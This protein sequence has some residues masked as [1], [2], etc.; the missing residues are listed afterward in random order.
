MAIKL[1]DLKKEIEAYKFDFNFLQK[2]DCS[3]E[4]NKKFKQMIKDGQPLPEGIHQYE[5]TS[6]IFYQVCEI[7]LTEKEKDEY[8]IFKQLEYLRS[9]K[10]SM[11]FFVILTIISMVITIIALNVR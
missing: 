2:I 11:L 1:V 8:I 7:E 3:M 5:D 4:E 6:Y 10:N 9:I